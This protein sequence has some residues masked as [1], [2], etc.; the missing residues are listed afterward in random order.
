MVPI[1]SQPLDSRDAKNVNNDSIAAAA[2]APAIDLLVESPS[3]AGYISG[4]QPILAGSSA[5]TLYRAA[6]AG[7]DLRPVGDDLSIDGQGD[8]LLADI[9]A[10]S[11]LLAISY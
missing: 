2:S 7:Y 1:V 9:L 8:D 3:A 4:P 11:S 5:T 10:E 6:T